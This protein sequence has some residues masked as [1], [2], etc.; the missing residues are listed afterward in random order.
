M[1]L[2]FVC[3]YSRCSRLDMLRCNYWIFIAAPPV[4]T[5]GN[6]KIRIRKKLMASFLFCIQITA[7][8]IWRQV[9]QVK[10][11]IL[12]LLFLK[13]YSYEI[14]QIWPQEFIKG[15]VA[16]TIKDC[17]LKSNL[18]YT[19]T[20]MLIGEDCL[21]AKILSPFLSTASLQYVPKILLTQATI[22]CLTNNKTKIALHNEAISLSYTLMVTQLAWVINH[23]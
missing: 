21:P 19:H 7:N 10:L 12:L 23:M 9:R 4:I 8:I 13:T 5:T 1:T 14:N 20:Q 15:P 18:K 2:V 3:V 6:S 22:E 17:F 11:Y 16:C